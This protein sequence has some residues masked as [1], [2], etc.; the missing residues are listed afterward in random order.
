MKRTLSAGKK[1]DYLNSENT[2]ARAEWVK[3]GEFH[4]KDASD[5]I[6]SLFLSGIE[7]KVPSKP[8]SISTSHSHSF[9]LI[10]F[11]EDIKSV[12]LKI[13]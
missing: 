6:K 2:L 7:Y 12:K 5:K 10:L 3:M 1:K 9:N 4:E 13:G 11:Y 8:T